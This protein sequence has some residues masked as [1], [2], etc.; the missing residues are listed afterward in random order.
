MISP[1]NWLY[2]T[3]LRW[4]K[5]PEETAKRKIIVIQTNNIYH[6]I[7]MFLKK[8]N[9]NILKYFEIHFLR[10]QIFVS[11]VWSVSISKE[12]SLLQG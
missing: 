11:T 6:S 10:N 2:N 8:P 12:E 4:R 5:S 9:L 1:N 7:Y 3:M